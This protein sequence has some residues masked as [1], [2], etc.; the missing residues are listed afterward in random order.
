MKKN[1]LF[2]AFCIFN[3]SLEAQSYNVPSSGTGSATT[4]TGT[5]YDN[6]GTSDYSNSTNGSYTIYPQTAGTF[7]SLTFTSFTVESGFD[8]LYIYDGTNTSAPLIGTYTGSVSPGTVYSTGSSGALTLQFYSDGSI[9]YAGFSATISCVTSVP[10]SDLIIQTPTLG[11]ASVTAGTSVSFTYTAKNQGGANAAT[12]Y[13]GFYLSADNAYD[14]GDSYLTNQSVSSLGGGLTQYKSGTV[15]IP[16]S[17]SVGNYYVL[18]YA[19]YNNTVNEDIES[20]NVNS[21]AISIMPAMVDLYITN[22][23]TSPTTTVAGGTTTTSGYEYNQGNS[24]VTSNS[25]GFYLSTDLS[26]DSSDTYLSFATA[27]YISAGSY[28]SFGQSI[29]IPSSTAP[30]NYYILSFADY[31]NSISETNENNN[32]NASSITITSPDKD[33]SVVTASANPTVIAFGGTSTISFS[34]LNQSY[35]TTSTSLG[36]YLSNDSLWDVSDTY[37]SYFSISSIAANSFYSSSSS[38]TIPSSTSPGNYF[39]LSYVDYT[40]S[41]SET[42]ENNNVKAIP[43]TITTPVI[44]LIIQTP[45]L[46]PSSTT[47]GGPVSVG[48]YIKNQG[49]TSSTS[50]NVGYYLSTDN[51]FDANDVYLGYSS[52]TT[53]AAGGSAYKSISLII[54]SATTTGNYYVLFFADYSSMVSESVETNNV[55]SMPVTIASPFVDLAITNQ[56]NPSSGTAGNSISISCY[57]INNGNSSATTSNV[58][59]YLSTD[60]LFD[61]GDTYL[62]YSSGTTLTAGSSAYKSLSVT[63]PSST[64]SGLYYIIYYADYSNAVSESNENNN[65]NSLSITIGG[66]TSYTVPLSGS[67]SA[68][69]C[70]GII[71]DDG[72]ASLSYSNNAYG[73]FTIYPQTAGNYVGLV[74]S[75]FSTQSGYD[76]LYIYNGTT[77]SDPLLGNYSGSTSPGT[78]FATGNTGALTLLF[79]SN[80]STV[81]S[82][83]AAS[84]ICSSTLPSPDLYIMNNVY[85]SSVS[86]TPGTSVTAGCYI[87]NQGTNSATASQVGYYLSTDSLWDVSDTYLNYSTGTNLNAGASSYKSATITI[88]STTTPGN[89]YVLY[90]A[91][92]SNQVSESA[93]GNNVNFLAISVNA[94]SVDLAISSPTLSSTNTTSGGTVTSSCYIYNYGNSAAASSNVG[95]YLSTDSTW[96]VSDVYLNYSSGTALSAGSSAYKSLTLTIPASTSPGNYYILYF[97]D[98]SGQVSETVETNNVSSL[99]ISISASMI[100]LTIVNNYLSSTT[101]AQGGT[102]NANCYILNQGNTGVSSSNVG[103]YL[104]TDSL[105]D[106]NDTYLNNQSGTTLAANSLSSRARSLTIPTGTAPGNYFILYFAD[107]SNMISEN[108]ETNNVVSSTISVVLPAIDLSILSPSANP[109]TVIAGN[110]L[111]AVST[112]FNSGNTSTTSSNIGYYLSADSVF[113]PSD[114]YLSYS[115]GT[116]LNAGIGAS[117]SLSITIPSSTI[118]GNYYVLFFADYSYMV[119]ESN[120]NNN[121]KF[122]SVTVA[123]PVIDLFIQTPSLNLNS[124]VPGGSVTGSC[125]IY[126]QGNASAVSSNVGYYLSNDTVWN[127]GDVYLNYSTGGTLAANTSG[128]KSITLTI[129]SSTTIGNYYILFFADYSNAVSESI[130]TNNVNF[131]S[132]TVANPFVDLVIS[133][134]TLTPSSLVAGASVSLTSYILNQGNSSSSSSNVGYYLSTDTI[135]DVSD[136]YLSYS[137]G[138]TLAAGA[139]S[140]KSSTPTI[141][142]GTT[143]GNYYILYYADYSG[144]VSESIETNN[145]SY[146]PITVLAPNVDLIIQTPSTSPTNVAAGGTTTATCYIYNQGTTPASISSVGFYL[147]VNTVWDGSDVFLNYQSGTTLAAGSSAYRSG[148][149]TIPTSTTPGTYYILYYAD[150]LNG[151]SETVETNNVSYNSITVSTPNIDLII[152]SGPYSPPT[153]VAGG[154]ISPYCYI[155]NQGN[156]TSSTSNVGYYL[157]TNTTYDVSDVY[158]GSSTGTS[159]AAAGSAYRSSTLTIPSSTVPGSYYIIFYADYNNV[160]SESIETN[161]TNYDNITI[162]T[163]SIDLVIQYQTAPTTGTAGSSISVDCYI[164]N[165]GTTASTSGNVGFYLSTDAVW[166]GGDT[167]LGYYATGAVSSGSYNYA[168]S[169]VTIPSSTPPGNYYVLYFA[170][171]SSAVN[172][173]NETNNVSYAPITISTP[174]IDLI[175]QTPGLSA[176][177]TNPG[178]SVSATCYIYNQGSISASYSY[179][180]YYLSTNNTW[181]AGDVYLNNSTGGTLTAGTSAYKNSTLTIPSTT[182]P[183]NYYILYFADYNAYVGEVN[184]NNNVNSLAISIVNPSIDLIIQYPYA[185]PSSSA[186]SSFTANCYIYNQGSTT[187]PSSNVG[188]YLSTDTIFDVGDTYLN[189]SYNASLAGGASSY[190]SA[191]LTIPASTPNGN[192]YI[193]FFA[194]YDFQS[195][196]T[197]ETNNVSYSPIIIAPLF[198]DLIIQTPYSPSSSVAGNSISVDCYIFNQG[199]SSASYSNVGYYLSNDTTW[200]VGDTYLNYSYGTT[201]TAGNSSYRSSTLTIPSA[202]PNGNYY[203]LFFAD[204]NFQETESVETNNVSFTSIA[205]VPTGPDLVI[206]TPSI[207]TSNVTAGNNVFVTDYIYNQGN[208]NS[209]SSSVGYYLSTDSLWDLSDV[210]L[211]YSYGGSLNYGSSSYRSANLVIPSNSY[212]GNYFI[213]YYA[214][215]NSLVSE[216]VET[217]NVNFLPLTIYGLYITVPGT[218]TTNISSCSDTIYDDGGPASNYLSN[219]DGSLTINPINS[220][221]KITLS[222]LDFSMENGWDFVKIY[223]GAD[224]SATLMGNFTG[225]NGPG[226][227]TA[228]NSNTS[229]A[230]TIRLTSDGTL[231]D[232]GFTAAVSCFTPVPF[233]DLVILSNTS[234]NPD[235]AFPGSTVN[236]DCNVLNQGNISSSSSSIGYY[237]SADTLYDG[238]DVFLSY[239]NVSS[240]SAGTS[241]SASTSVTIPQATTPGNYYIIFYADFTSF[242][243][244]SDENNN[245]F[246]APVTIVNPVKV[247]N[248]L[249]VSNNEFKIFPNP[250]NGNFELNFFN[251]GTMNGKE[252]KVSNMLG[253]TVYKN[254]VS[255]H[256]SRMN[257]DLNYLE[258]GIYF[259]QIQGGIKL[260]IKKL[261][262]E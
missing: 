164:Y 231:N 193:L 17:A 167:Y 106:A 68:T 131:V 241:N 61:V 110:S 87:A 95:Y 97:A 206:L 212:S 148:T 21:V 105:W 127:S 225:T 84:I 86:V 209:S 238:S 200:D 46:S 100:D 196:E 81:Y 169:T 159:L 260:E 60:N 93:E 7:V 12:S 259:V 240:I 53:L 236:V 230:L 232:L 3:I 122:V 184:E 220:G 30:G 59:Y 90:F 147:S 210:F 24:T 175:I 244:E 10:L 94:P 58:G 221:D 226:T 8:N 142:T 112:I 151:E 152:Q 176:T 77:T 125:Y 43:V 15:T 248:Q 187:S 163:P 229:G 85:L 49:T 224:T 242:V 258:K 174:S 48:C 31:N 218:G 161:N 207:S 72:G 42:N 252:I 6:G 73:T 118:P 92:Y 195:N 254:I 83:F 140:Y 104:S 160:E 19:D 185:P 234:A 102:F 194:D 202:T 203:I 138:T 111:T 228:S 20:N 165:Q 144:N 37:L 45:S 133:S 223:D 52:G 199:N 36:F 74:F 162:T 132:I 13:T 222:F 23:T 255:T 246:Y 32:I 239:F 128:Y 180:G 27:S 79:S 251:E 91:D 44:D 78:I 80:S 62:G 170:D 38:I 191:S 88:P 121:V 117:K 216:S 50:S 98:Y 181:D 262:K 4:C 67:N 243:S 70:S 139:S 39:V 120:E 114:T 5:I 154:T 261:V 213:L 89:Y 189:Y 76:Y 66:G 190:E 217:N 178:S 155:Y 134:T 179:V 63:I 153:G 198:V 172:E 150:Y 107:Y 82:G 215:Y 253:E 126:N 26:W 35:Q 109:S 25:I 183:G 115:S 237:L 113:D 182:T 99:P 51:I 9:V 197:V 29:T 57:I 28:F 47:A 65:V 211:N 173:T 146:K 256:K 71:Y 54:P 75:S 116:T 245:V 22:Q 205:I 56:Y 14:P 129:P 2:F 157:S 235:T 188:F 214:D 249:N 69:T 1:L 96:D 201:L 158:L 124:T 177:T 18:F 103:F 40:N 137:T 123:A 16:S 64:T 141:P 208:Q 171:Y 33:L 143:P 219:S 149:L 119:V 145:V 34:V 257:L 166:D 233:P 250:G 55:S 156:I 247:L 41:I 192:Y 130:E 135:W 204:Y 136:T 11:N 186:G 108:I 168:Y 227:I 101:V